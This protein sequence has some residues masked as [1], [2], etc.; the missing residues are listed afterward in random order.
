[1]V[2]Q[3]DVPGAQTVTL[4][5]SM[6]RVLLGVATTEIGCTLGVVDCATVG[7][8]EVDVT[9]GLDGVEAGEAGAG[10]VAGALPA[11]LEPPPPPPQ[12]DSTTNTPRTKPTAKSRWILIEPP[13][14]QIVEREARRQDGR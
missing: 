10:D 4:V 12:P 8:G 9:G 7:V 1:M 6:L 14:T 5:T 11:L 2:T 13:S 3:F